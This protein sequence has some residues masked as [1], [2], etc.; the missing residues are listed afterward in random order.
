MEHE[1]KWK[2]KQTKLITLLEDFHLTDIQH[3]IH[4]TEP[5]HISLHTII[6]IPGLILFSFQSS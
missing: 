2:Q 6:S 5:T 4:K 3:H 1:Q